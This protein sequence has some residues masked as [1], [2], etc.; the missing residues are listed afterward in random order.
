MVRVKS[1][2]FLFLRNAHFDS[3]S[4][5]QKIT[6]LNNMKDGQRKFGPDNPIY[7]KELGR[8]F[9]NTDKK[10][11]ARVFGDKTADII[12]R[13][14][15]LEANVRQRNHILAKKYREIEHKEAVI[16]PLPYRNYERN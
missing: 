14:W 3:E 11:V 12:H 13:T 9:F 15:E 10:E 1:A 16:I 6:L 5:E 4:L 8:W 2:Y 7:Q